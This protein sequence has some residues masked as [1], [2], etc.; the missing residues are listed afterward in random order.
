MIRIF[1]FAS[2]DPSGYYHEF[3]DQNDRA[4]LHVAGGGGAYGGVD[5]SHHM[6]TG[7]MGPGSG[8][9]WSDQYRSVYGNFML[10]NRSSFDRMYGTGAWD[11]Y[12]TSAYTNQGSSGSGSIPGSTVITDRT[13]IST[14]I[15]W[16]SSGFNVSIVSAFGNT[17]LIGSFGSLGSY[18]LG[19]DGAIRFA[20]PTAGMVAGE[21]VAAGGGVHDVSQAGLNF[22]AGYEGYSATTYKDVAGLPTIGY[23]HLIKSGES[24]GTLSKNA[25]L[26][27]LRKDASFAVNAVNKYVK[28]PLSQ[29]QFDA[30]TSLTFNIGAGAFSNSTVLK[31]VNSG[32]ILS[33]DQSFM[34]WNKARID[35]VLTPVQGLTNR[36]QAEANL[37]L[38]GVY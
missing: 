14:I 37:F 9:H 22:I 16:I 6:R 24:F 3:W 10:G 12:Y 25:A 36:R 1:T 26:Q 31:N 11:S 29:N 35:G 33:I 38:N 4:L 18:S 7:G 28:V 17:N 21:G 30:L 13:N 2:T 19:A 34:M 15:G 27:L 32:N 5:W 20:N 8:N 23:G